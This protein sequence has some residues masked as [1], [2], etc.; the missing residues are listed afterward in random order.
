M[1]VGCAAAVYRRRTPFGSIVSFHDGTENCVLP[2]VTGTH[3]I[4]R[5]VVNRGPTMAD[6]TK[7]E[8]L[9]NARGLDDGYLYI[10]LSH[11]FARKLAGVLQGGKTAQAPKVRLTDSASYGCPGFTGSVRPPLSNELYPIDEDVAVPPPARAFNIDRASSENLFFDPIEP[12]AAVC[13]AFTEPLRHPHKSILIPGAVPPPPC[14]TQEDTRLRRP[15]LNRGGASIAHLGMSSGNNSEPGFSGRPEREQ[16][17]NH[18]WGSLE[19]SLKRVRQSAPPYQANPFLAQTHPP[20]QGYAHPAAFDRPPWQNQGGSTGYDQGQQQFQPYQH[21][22]AQGRWQPHQQASHA[23]NGNQY[24]PSNNRGQ[25]GANGYRGPPPAAN[26]YREQ[27]PAYGEF[28][29]NRNQQISGHEQPP[30]QQQP[31]FS[32]QQQP[33]FSQQ[34]QPRFQQQQQMP[35]TGQ[36]RQGYNFRAMVNDRGQQAG[37][38][39]NSLQNS[40][41]RADTNVMN[42]LRAQLANTLRQ[43]NNRHAGAGNNTR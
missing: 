40:T 32:Q 1:V 33:R 9:C 34:Q 5:F 17:R 30:Q 38:R 19:P 18:G 13:V 6:W 36:L 12:N 20:Q 35:A 39:S 22:T 15:R 10:H 23:N 42:N 43:Q 7:T 31:R 28:Q 16:E 27:P 29:G 26:N 4:L 14:L 2:I 41:S 8:L 21:L 3:R 11:P 24:N 25:S 37:D